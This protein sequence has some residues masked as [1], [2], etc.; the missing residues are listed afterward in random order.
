MYGV[1]NFTCMENRLK[2][3]AAL[4][5]TFTAASTVSAQII[6][7]DFEPDIT[8]TGAMDTI[9]L[10]LDNNG[11]V[12]F[13][14]GQQSYFYSYSST[15]YG[16]SYGFKGNFILEG[17][18]T[19]ASVVVENLRM[20]IYPGSTTTMRIPVNFD[21]DANI[22]DQL[23]FN[24][25]STYM[26]IAASLSYYGVPMKMGN[27]LGKTGLLAIR[28]SGKKGLHYGWIRVSVNDDAS[29]ITIHDYA[30]HKKAGKPI[31]AGEQ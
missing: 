2:Q 19:S 18:G 13:R 28:F 6:Y 26:L 22:N 7:H 11:V 31:K 20:E 8:L 27:H 15:N 1:F 24:T 10:D 9:S 17:D 25:I 3:Y 12:D 14:F 23:N 5:A 4:A 16:S 21:V 30:Y 29:S